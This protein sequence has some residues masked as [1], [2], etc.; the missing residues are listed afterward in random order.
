[1]SAKQDNALDVLKKA[2]SAGAILPVATGAALVKAG[3]AVKVEGATGAGKAK[4]TYR[5]V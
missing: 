2:G 3:K 4:A 5:A 1:M